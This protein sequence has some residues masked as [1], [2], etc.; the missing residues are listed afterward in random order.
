MKKPKNRKWFWNATK[1]GLFHKDVLRF[2]G[3]RIDDYHGSP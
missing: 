2:S 3:I 1:T